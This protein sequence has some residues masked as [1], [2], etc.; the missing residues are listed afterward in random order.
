MPIAQYTP[1][2]N[3]LIADHETAKLCDFGLSRMISKVAGTASVHTS[4]A[5]YLSYE[6][7][8]SEGDCCHPTTAGDVYALACISLEVSRSDC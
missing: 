6:L 7:V 5:R 2:G 8:V 4:T 1:K 3:I